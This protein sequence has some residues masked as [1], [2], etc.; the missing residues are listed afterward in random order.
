[1]S[2]CV[3]YT[4]HAIFSSSLWSL[5][6]LSGLFVGVPLLRNYHIHDLLI[7]LMI[8]LEGGFQANVVVKALDS[9]CSCGG[10]VCSFPDEARESAAAQMLANLR[11]M[12]KSG[13]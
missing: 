13:Q 8:L 4:K 3:P 6:T 2:F 11:S 5:M 9:E 7:N 1:M 10:N 12:A